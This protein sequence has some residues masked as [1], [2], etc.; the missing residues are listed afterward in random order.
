MGAKYLSEKPPE[1]H[2]YCNQEQPPD[3]C[4]WDG[5]GLHPA[6]LVYGEQ[7][8]ESAKKC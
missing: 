7:G 1:P 4:A 2:R 8:D 5:N 6:S 3:D